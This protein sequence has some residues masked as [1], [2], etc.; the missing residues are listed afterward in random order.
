MNRKVIVVASI[1]SASCWAAAI[2]AQPPR[3]FRPAVHQM[4]EVS[5]AEDVLIR[6]KKAPTQYDAN[7]KPV[8]PTQ[9]QL[10]DLKGDPALPGYRAEFDDLKPGQLL[11][12]RLGRP[13]KSANNAQGDKTQWKTL[14]TITARVARSNDQSDADAK[15][16]AKKAE[17]IVLE[18][19]LGDLAQAGLK[20]SPG[21]RNLTLGDDVYATRVMIVADAQ[22]QKPSGK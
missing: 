19:N 13:K 10:K 8:T 5:L 22:P 11:E 3:R 7:G 18:A 15:P 12:I 2:Q 4:L 6:Y 1:L 9:A 17:K 20:V 14:T 16:G 21:P